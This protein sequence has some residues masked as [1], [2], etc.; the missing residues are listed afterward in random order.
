MGICTDPSEFMRADLLQIKQHKHVYESFV[1]P[2]DTL[3]SQY[4]RTTTASII[5]LI[6]NFDES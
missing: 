5:V 6:D 2:V 3:P 4:Y 1:I